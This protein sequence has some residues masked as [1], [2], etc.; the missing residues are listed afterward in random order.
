MNPQPANDNYPRTLPFA[1]FGSVASTGGGNDDDSFWKD[2][3]LWF[4]SKSPRQVKRACQSAKRKMASSSMIERHSVCRYSVDLYGRPRIL[5][6][7]EAILHALAWPAIIGVIIGFS[8]AI[9]L[10]ILH[11]PSPISAQQQPKPTWMASL[12]SSP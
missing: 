2:L 12:E 6:D 1:A 5:S 7:W 10:V 9:S 11:S 4:S 3:V 8:L